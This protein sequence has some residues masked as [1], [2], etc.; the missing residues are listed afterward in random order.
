MN[1]DSE[2]DFRAYLE[3]EF[4]AAPFLVGF[5]ECTVEKVVHR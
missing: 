4:T 3:S 5:Q 1:L 2:F